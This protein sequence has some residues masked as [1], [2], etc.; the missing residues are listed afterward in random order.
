MYGT[1]SA[2]VCCLS[3]R[4]RVISPNNAPR[5]HAQNLPQF[6]P[7]NEIFLKL[8]VAASTVQSRYLS[9]FRY[10]ITSTTENKFL[11]QTTSALS[12]EE[13]VVEKQWK[14]E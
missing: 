10:E 13:G 2:K 7:D 6:L 12:S 3:C 1:K 5:F 11:P 8:N 14:G 9:Y 4:F